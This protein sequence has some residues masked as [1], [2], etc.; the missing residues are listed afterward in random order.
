M[1]SMNTVDA[2]AR[3]AADHAFRCPVG[4]AIPG[5]TIWC[6]D[7]PTDPTPAMFTPKFYMVVQGAKRLAIGG[8]SHVFGRGRYGVASVGLPFTSQVI[9]A[10]RERPYLAVELAL[11]AGVVAS[12]LLGMRDTGA[13]NGPAFAAAH[14]S[15]DIAGPVDRLVQL[16]YTPDDIP[17]LARQFERELYYRLLQGPVG[18]TLQQVVQTNTR[19]AQ[20]RTAVEWI[21]G[22]VD[23]AM[24]VED[25]ATSVGMS[26]TSF[27]RH[28][29]AVT[30]YSPLAYQR[31]LR[32]IEAQRL[33]ASGT[34]DVTRAAF[35]TGYASSSQF[36]REYKRMFGMPPIRAAPRHG[37]DAER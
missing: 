16:L 1:S 32:L 9:A 24:R 28:F 25:L 23:Q 36:S 10:S 12:L 21:C 37:Q 3:I 6:G 19:L 15:D 29:K 2:L 5:M 22:N 7:R 30:A 20:I 11:D 14:A 31:H 35:A 34:T 13:R 27:H 18:E 4:T 33:I 17:V 8:E 26:V